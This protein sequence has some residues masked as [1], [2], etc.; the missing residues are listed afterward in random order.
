MI[1]ITGSTGFVGK[2]LTQALLA[3][4]HKLR[5]LL[6]P[7]SNPAQLRNIPAEKVMA[8]PFSVES[9]RDIFS[10]VEYVIHC[11]GVTMGLNYNDF[12]R[13]NVLY[14][15]NLLEAI[16][17][18][19]NKVKKFVL[20]SSQSAS[21]P[22]NTSVPKTEWDQDNPLSWYGLSKL[23]AEKKLK[24]SGFPYIILRPC[25]IYGP[26]DHEFLP[27]F[28]MANN[29]IHLIAGNGKNQV[30]LIHVTDFVN[31]I[32][33]TI[34]DIVINKTY[35]VAGQEILTW[36]DITAITRKIVNKKTFTIYLPKFLLS[37]LGYFTYWL[38]LLIRKPLLLNK[39]KTKEMI[40]KYWTCDTSLIHQDLGFKPVKN[41]LTGFEE[42]FSWYLNHKWIK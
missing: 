27:L 12:Y 31:A 38:S 36:K 39:D 21:G 24:E 5:L 26:E 22:N 4:N 19:G 33:L 42:T 7:D 10:D 1:L 29:R 28:K 18:Y 40:Q 8:N 35:Y 30:N 13:G 15:Q 9:M 25:S 34:N 16:N 37:A 17:L 20:I 6:R 2:N 23:L 14:T 41:T 3:K 32:E 11:A